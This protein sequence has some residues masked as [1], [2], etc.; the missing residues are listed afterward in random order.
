MQNVGTGKFLEGLEDG[1]IFTSP[2]NGGNH[3]K[4][5]LQNIGNNQYWLKK[6]DTELVVDSNQ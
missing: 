4:W 6:F 5:D 1:K 3:Q 2:P